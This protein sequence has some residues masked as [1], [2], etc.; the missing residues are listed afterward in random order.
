MLKSIKNVFIVMLATFVM[1]TVFIGVVQAGGTIDVTSAASCQRTTASGDNR[2]GMCN[3]LR[4]GGGTD[5][6]RGNAS[7]SHQQ[8]NLSTSATSVE[9][10]GHATASMLITVDN[11]VTSVNAMTV[12]HGNTG[13][14]TRGRV[15][16]VRPMSGVNLH[17]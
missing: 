4:H 2:S 17:Q 16:L 5:P 10:R 3:G 1:T 7:W 13:T 8:F 15:M 11:G 14:V 6:R 12:R 9:R